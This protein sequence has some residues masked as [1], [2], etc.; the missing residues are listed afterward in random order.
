MANHCKSYKYD[1]TINKSNDKNLSLICMHFHF[2]LSSN[3]KELIVMPLSQFPLSCK[4]YRI[5][6]GVLVTTLRIKDIVLMYGH[7]FLIMIWKFIRYCNVYEELCTGI[8]LYI[9]NFNS[10]LFFQFIIAVDKMFIFLM[11][12]VNYFQDM[13]SAQVDKTFEVSTCFQHLLAHSSWQKP[14]TR[15]ITVMFFSINCS[16]ISKNCESKSLDNIVSLYRTT[17]NW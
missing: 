10:Q 3:L 16:Q 7:M 13:F 14:I 5:R 15:E 11:H 8:D 4:S 1:T 12:P 6:S 2:P 17:L 9:I